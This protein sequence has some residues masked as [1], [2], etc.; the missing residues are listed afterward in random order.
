MTLCLFTTMYCLM[1]QVCHL[2]CDGC[3]RASLKVSFWG[4]AVS[5]SGLPAA[6]QSN[7]S[8]RSHVLSMRLYGEEM[9]SLPAIIGAVVERLCFDIF[10]QIGACL[11]RRSKFVPVGERRCPCRSF[12]RERY[13]AVLEEE[14]DSIS[15]EEFLLS[16]WISASNGT[17]L[18]LVRK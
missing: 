5:A 13:V 9:V 1:R 12:D 3:L 16:F 10:L 14:A 11:Y 17:F 6:S 15:Y 18:M 7:K 2:P 8:P 4:N